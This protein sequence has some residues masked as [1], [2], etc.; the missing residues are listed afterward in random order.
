MVPATPALLSSVS[1]K[2]PL[3][4]D[5]IE[6]QEKAKQAAG[7]AGAL[8]AQTYNNSHGI[9]GTI[10]TNLGLFRAYACAYLIAHPQVNTTTQD[11]L[12]SMDPPQNYG[13]ALNI[14]CYSSQTSWAQYEAVKAEILEHLHAAAS[15]FGLVVYTTPDRNTFTID[16]APAAPIAPAAPAPSTAQ[17]S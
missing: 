7:S 15:D 11:M 3:I 1:D 6:K 4:K 8:F 14:N 5:F 13:V 17:A 2:Y 10:D 16:T 9:N 12:I